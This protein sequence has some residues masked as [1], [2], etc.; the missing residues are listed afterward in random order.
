MAEKVSLLDELRADQGKPTQCVVCLWIEAQPAPER[1]DWHQAMLAH[2]SIYTHA[3][4]H[5]AILR[6]VEA[7]GSSY[8]GPV[9]GR[10]SVEGHRKNRH[11]PR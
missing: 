6:R 10:G 11:G 5:R 2:T 7:S 3:S 4:I 9:V 1:A 8:T